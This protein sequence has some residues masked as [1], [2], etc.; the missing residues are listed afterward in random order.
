MNSKSQILRHRELAD[1]QILLGG[2]PCKTSRGWLGYC[3]VTLFSLNGEWALFDTGHYSDRSILLSVLNEA[4]LKPS[5]ISHIVLSHLHFDHVLNL[6]LFQ[7]ASVTLSLAELDYARRVTSGEIED[8]AIPDLWSSLL[9]GRRIQIVEEKLDLGETIQLVT[10]PG[11]TPGSLVMFWGSPAPIAVC[12]D[13]IKNGWEVLT[14]EPTTGCADRSKAKA[15]ISQVLER[16]GVIVPGH[17]R[18]LVRHS[19]GLD[20]LTDFSW[21]IRGHMYPRPQDEVL[22]NLSRP[23]GFYPWP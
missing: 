8:P 14:G 6:S 17:D 10:M 22:F 13:V 11:H 16:A 5:D 15:S 3:T 18:P 9:N 21:E 20:Y 12:G 2:I 7:K 4:R 23:A 1:L 19:N